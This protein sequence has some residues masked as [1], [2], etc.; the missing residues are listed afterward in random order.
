MIEFV[1]KNRRM[2]YY[3]DDDVFT[4]RSING[5]KETKDETWKP[6]SFSN[7]G[8]GYMKCQLSVGGKYKNLYKE[9]LIYLA[10]NPEWNIFGGRMEYSAV[11]N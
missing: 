9:R 1:V 6:I 10:K 4:V 5:G 7:N 8:K 2:R 3:P 11:E